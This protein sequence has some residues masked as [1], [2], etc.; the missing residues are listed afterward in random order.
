MTTLPSI[1]WPTSRTSCAC[2][3]ALA[4]RRKK[5]ATNRETATTVTASTEAA[6]IVCIKGGACPDCPISNWKSMSRQESSIE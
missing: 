6:A 2:R 3:H 1:S 4:R 5:L